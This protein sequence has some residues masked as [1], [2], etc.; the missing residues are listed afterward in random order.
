MAFKN[1]GPVFMILALDDR[2]PGRA[3]LGMEIAG[4]L[5]NAGQ[6]TLLALNH[7]HGRMAKEGPWSSLF[8][9]NALGGR[10]GRGGQPGHFRVSGGLPGAL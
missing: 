5:V 1:S 8:F 4:S 9:S 3:A 10:M 2:S 6:K 7:C